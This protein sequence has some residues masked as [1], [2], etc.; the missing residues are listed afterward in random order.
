MSYLSIKL[1]RPYNAC[2]G[3]V[4]ALNHIFMRLFS[5]AQINKIATHGTICPHCRRLIGQSIEGGRPPWDETLD[6]YIICFKRSLGTI[7]ISF[8]EEKV[9]LK[10]L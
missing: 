7:I 9:D 1:G 2:R 6:Y 3:D 5:H 4:V 10:P 8:V